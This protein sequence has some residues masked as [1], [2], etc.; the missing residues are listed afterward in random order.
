[1]VGCSAEGRLGLEVEE[2]FIQKRP[3]GSVVGGRLGVPS[4]SRGRPGTDN[5]TRERGGAI[6][7]RAE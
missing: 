3:R 5:G 4:C 7:T 6:M 2:R 1:M